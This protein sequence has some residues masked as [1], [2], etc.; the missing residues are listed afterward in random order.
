V[1]DILLRFFDIH[2]KPVESSFNNRVI[3][4]HLEQLRQTARSVGIAGGSRKYKA[5]LGA[6]NGR[7]INVLITD[8]LTAEKLSSEKKL[9]GLP[10]SGNTNMV[11]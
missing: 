9:D 10:T 2:G 4:M 7:L 1:G 6:L 11:F 3:S 8:R 5:I